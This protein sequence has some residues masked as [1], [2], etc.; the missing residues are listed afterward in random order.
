MKVWWRKVI[1]TNSFYRIKTTDYILTIDFLTSEIESLGRLCNYIV[2][3]PRGEIRYIHNAFIKL[4]DIILSYGKDSLNYKD[5][6]VNILLSNSRITRILDERAGNFGF[7]Q[8]DMDKKEVEKFSFDKDGS[9]TK[10]FRKNKGIELE[11]KYFNLKDTPF[12]YTFDDIT[13]NSSLPSIETPSGVI[14]IQFLSTEPNRYQNT[15][16][17]YGD[18]VNL[19]LV[20]KEKIH[21]FE[22]VFI[23]LDKSLL[24]SNGEN[25]K[26]YQNLI[27][28]VLFDEK[29]NEIV[30]SERMGSFGILSYTGTKLK[31]ILN[32][33]QII[34][35]KNFREKK[36]IYPKHEIIK[37]K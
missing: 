3:L 30:L 24:V 17:S 4:D 37:R 10:T 20:G 2:V 12:S 7:I 25:G 1:A 27:G 26:N 32:P 22:K 29:R 31:K 28:E 35:I 34:N 19:Y 6:L 14:L 18:M 11:E 13:F 16:K 36:N 33:N 21:V 9:D 8:Y 5:E 15:S 23:E